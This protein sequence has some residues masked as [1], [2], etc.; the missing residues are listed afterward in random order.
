MASAPEIRGY[1]L[2][3]PLGK[4]GMGAVYL[5]RQIALG[6]P[7]AIKF[8]VPEGESDP[9]QGHARFRREA[10]LMARVSHPHIVSV[11]DFGESDG[12]PYL[13]MEYVEGGDLRR[14]MTPGEPWPADRVR[15]LILPVGEALAYLH[16]RGII[17]RDLKP[18][19]VLLDDEEHPRVADF[20]IAVLRAGNGSL[21]QTGW[22]LGTMGY[23]APEQHYGLKVDERADQYSLAAVA[24]E[25]LTGYAP[26]GAFKPP[27]RHNPGLDPEVDAVIMRA[28]EESPNA[29]YATIS[30]FTAALDRSLTTSPAR[31]T[32][33]APRHPIRAALALLAVAGLLMGFVAWFRAGGPATAPVP[34]D[35]PQD[36]TP[37]A[38]SG[39]DRVLPAGEIPPPVDR[40][41]ERLKE[42]HAKK[43]WQE[44]GSPTGPAGDAMEKE[45]WEQ[46]T[47]IVKEEIDLIA[48]GIWQERGSPKDKE[49][50]AIRDE[51]SREAKIRLYR[52]LTNQD[53]PEE[54]LH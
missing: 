53:P 49:G 23:V 32:T 22:R 10:E 6:R 35:S 24:Y 39:D 44:R 20:G 43:I 33:N 18:E 5:A 3:N 26:F 17:H 9:E 14:R 30:E 50:E 19:N 13:I 7:V 16:R 12:R 42:L 47:R 45:N 52:R 27:S 25:L 41:L 2:L 51:C 1:E 36:V 11:H 40:L 21:T 48:Y 46:A 8:L 34:A 38:V 28:L 4:G 31:P 15:A 29:R 37:P 54:L